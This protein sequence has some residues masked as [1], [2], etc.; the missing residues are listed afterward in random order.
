MSESRGFL[1]FF[2]IAA[3]PMMRGDDDETADEREN[4]LRYATA[5]DYHA[6]FLPPSPPERNDQPDHL[7][8]QPPEIS[9]PLSR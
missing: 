1:L 4:R 3:M 2:L 7:T 6:Y 9:P 5:P 8:H